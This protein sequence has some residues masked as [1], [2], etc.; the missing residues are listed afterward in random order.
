[1]LSAAVRAENYSDFGNTL[2]GKVAGRL[3]LSENLAVRGSF[4]T[5]FRAPS[6]AQMY[7]NSTFTN[8][9]SGQAVDVK[10]ANNSDALTTALGIPKLK[11]ET[12]QNISLGLTA[13]PAKGLS[14]TLDG[15][16][17]TVA[18]RVVLTGGFDD[19]DD[20]A[21]PFLQAENVSFA[22]FFTNAVNTQTRGLDLVVSYA[23][24]LKN[25]QRI[26]LSAALNVNQ[27]EITDI[28]T[29]ELLTGKEDSYFGRREQL[30]LLASAPPMKGV[31]SIDYHKSKFSASLRGTYFAGITLEDWVGS[32]DVYDP[33]VTLDLS[34]SYALSDAL[35]AT[36]GVS[37]LTD[38]LPTLQ[39][40]ETEG[41]GLYDP[42]QMGSMGRY[43][44]ARA[45][46]RF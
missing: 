34:L 11:Q 10:L 20:I 44:F 40:S 4:S 8:F 28:Y 14:V 38:A 35:R 46:Y 18:D 3:A 41:G 24:N 5:G 32:D 23:K 21:G 15:Y 29:N 26:N 22:Q 37:N 7:F 2:N 33:R 25:A 12:A 17:V 27:M 42:V 39:D 36:L 45:S 1:M 13:T 31:A 16:Q 6:L 30:F 43:F 19:A 9:V